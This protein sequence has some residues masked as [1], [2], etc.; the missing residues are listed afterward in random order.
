[1]Y[2]IRFNKWG[3]HKKLRAHQVAELL[4]QRGKRAAVGKTSVSFVHGR[5]IDTERLNTYLRRVSPARRKE[6]EAILKGKVELATPQKRSIAVIICRTP[7]PEPKP[8]I[9]PT[10]RRIEAPENLRLPE[11][12]L[13]IVQCYVGG[14]FES[15]LFQTTPDNELVFPQ[16]GKTWLDPVSSARQ[17]FIN[18]FTEQGFR[19]IK[20]TFEDYRAVMLRQD[21]S[22][23]VETCLALGALL[24]CG[25]GLAESLINY[26][27]GMSRILFGSRHPLHLLFVRLQGASPSDITQIMRLVIQS[28]LKAV[29][30]S[31]RLKPTYLATI[32]RAMLNNNFIS[33]PSAAADMQALLTD[34]ETAAAA[35]VSSISSSRSSSFSSPTTSPAAAASSSSPAPQQKASDLALLR[36]HLTWLQT[37][38]NQ[39]TEAQA[40]AQALLS[41]SA[42]RDPRLVR[43]SCYTMLRTLPASPLHTRPADAIALLRR[44]LAVCEERFGRSDNATVT[45]LA[46]LRGYL[47]R[48]GREGEAEGVGREFEGRWGEGMGM[49]G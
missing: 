13:Q 20:V 36:Y 1:M 2:K 12:C 32:Y 17:L 33:G 9:E 16:R 19:L 41:P 27:C 31:S 3:L 23:L 14:A 5:K 44:S 34:L 8:G 46:A 26:A 42:P 15:S 7:S 22:L 40:A 28:Y 45:V 24:H 6:L 10:L 39:P 11:E 4:V 38:H 47:R 35:P 29:Q 37:Q 49:D 30:L 18:G 21:P 25:P 48:V 43:F